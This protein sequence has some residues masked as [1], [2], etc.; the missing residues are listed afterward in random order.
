MYICIYVYMYICIYVYMYICIYIY[1]YI[2]K[3]FQF[4]ILNFEKF[5]NQ[6]LDKINNIMNI[7]LLYI[8]CLL[9]YI[10][11]YIYIYNNNMKLIVFIKIIGIYFWISSYI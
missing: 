5:R 8:L 4:Q 3:K 10:Y 1:I 2:S 11:I 6:C 7:L 9:T